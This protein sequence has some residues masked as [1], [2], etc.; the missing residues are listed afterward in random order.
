MVLKTLKI[1]AK[2][3][4][5]CN[6]NLARFYSNLSLSFFT[7]IEEVIFCVNSKKNFIFIFKNRIFF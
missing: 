5:I 1:L 6:L 7:K 3:Y 4:E 2:N